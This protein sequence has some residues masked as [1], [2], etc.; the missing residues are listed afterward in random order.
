[1][2]TRLP[3]EPIRIERVEKRKV[4][5]P[6]RLLALLGAIL[7]FPSVA[8]TL[9]A[10]TFTSN[11]FVVIRGWTGSAIVDI[12]NADGSV[13]VTCVS[14]CGGASPFE[15]NDAFVFNTSGTTNIGA[16][17]DDTATNAVT[18][19]SAGVPRMSTNRVLY[20]DLSKTTANATAL[21]VTGTAGTF[22]VTGTI[23]ATQSG[24][25][26]V[27]PGNTVNTTPWLV[28]EVPL[29]SCG[30]T[31]AEQVWA[32]VPTSS[33][34]AFAA[35]TC[36]TTVGFCNTNATPQT[37]SL[38]DNA[39]SPLVLINAMSLQGLSCVLL[40]FGGTKFTSGVKW[41]AGGTGVTGAILGHQ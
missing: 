19:N 17:V 33:T 2:R 35:S 25:W 38:T 37:I 10:Q 22:P 26:T 24:T 21:L 6:F 15:D 29:N 3:Y 1:M 36:V 13:D 27:Q 18:E 28:E 9:Y 11:N 5:K 12:A 32:A 23:A 30:N 34:A 39:G 41:F 40:P 31:L 8:A 7:I 14:G 20:T 16:V 4:R